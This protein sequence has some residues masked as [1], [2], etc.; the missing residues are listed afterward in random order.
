MRCECCEDCCDWEAT[1]A[2]DMEKIYKEIKKKEKVSMIDL[3]DE[4]L[5]IEN[6]VFACNRALMSEN[7]YS[8]SKIADVL[9]FHVINPLENL[10]KAI[11][12]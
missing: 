4:L 1:G 9:L 7:E 11:E 8:A 12:K 6:V 3:S 5:S 10:R 2:E